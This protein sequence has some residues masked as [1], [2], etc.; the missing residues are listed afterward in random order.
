MNIYVRF[1]G[2]WLRRMDGCIWSLIRR[3][4]LDDTVCD[5]VLSSKCSNGLK[6]YS[7]IK[8]S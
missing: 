7:C 4:D 8:V 6:N 1:I 5:F 3:R 2:G